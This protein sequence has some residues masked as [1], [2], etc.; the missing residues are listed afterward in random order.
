MQPQTENPICP[1]CGGVFTGAFCARCGQKKPSPQRFTLKHFFEESIEGFTHF[2]NKFFRSIK[3]LF[4]KPGSLSR[5]FEQGRTV[6]FMKPVQLF[7][8]S[9]FLFFLLVGRSNIF[10]VGLSSYLTFGN[11][12][13]Y[14]TKEAVLK[15]F[16]SGANL[17]EVARLFNERIASQSKAFIVLF[18]P[19]FAVFCAVLF[20]KKKRY[21]SLHLTF[22]THFFTFL[23]LYFILFHF[24]IE[25]TNQYVFHLS[26]GNFDLLAVVLNLMVFVVYFAL[27]ATRFYL[28]KWYWAVVISLLMA[29]LFLLSLQAYR[30]FLFYK[31]IHTF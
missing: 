5:H 24:I 8:V 29:F 9:N 10:A 21:F 17:N 23:L 3:L 27:A 30:M 16:G 1:S 11:Y 4:F 28:T 6:P 22:A 19:V 26:V 13:R 14:G 18:I 2:D 20:L 31:I 25:V 15:K 12:T 7:I